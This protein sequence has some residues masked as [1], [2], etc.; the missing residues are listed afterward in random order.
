MKK[1]IDYI[2]FLFCKHSKDKFIRNIYGDEIIFGT[3]NFSRS[4]WKCNKCNSAFYDSDL[5]YDELDKK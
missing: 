4:I 1:I 5:N 3:P 2:K